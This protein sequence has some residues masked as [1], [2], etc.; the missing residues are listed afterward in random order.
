VGVVGSAAVPEVAAV[1]RGDADCGI[2][3]D[4]V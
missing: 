3:R 1:G 2:A 4:I